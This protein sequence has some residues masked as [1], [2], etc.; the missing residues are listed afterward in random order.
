MTAWDDYRNAAQRLDAVRRDATATVAAQTAAVQAAHAELT[1]VR[2]RLALQQARFGDLAGRAGMPVPPLGPD[3][4]VPAPPDPA[5]ASAMLRAAMTDLDSADAALSEVDTGTV[6][7]GPFPDWAQTP[8][9]LVVYGAFALAVLISQLFLFF[10]ASGPAAS[11]GALLCGATLPALGYGASW[12]SI[13]LLYGKVDRTPVL[14]AAISAAPV[15]LLCGG[16]AASAF[17]R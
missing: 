2:Q 10:V 12:L 11:V 6:T 16:I 7:R 5:A 14:G 3:V 9:N 8:R 4:A 13:T 17:F 15:V 1:A